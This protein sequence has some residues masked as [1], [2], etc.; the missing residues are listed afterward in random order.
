MLINII[1]SASWTLH[2]RYYLFHRL[3]YLYGIS[4]TI[5]SWCASCL[6]G[7][8]QY[9]TVTGQSSRPAEVFF[10]VP[11]GSVLGPI[12]F[13]LC[14]VPLIALI[15]PQWLTGRKTPS[16]LLTAPLC[17][18]TEIHPVSNQSF[19]DD[20]QLL[21]SCPPDQ[22][23]AIA[24]TMQ[25]CISDVKTWMTQ[26]KLKLND[27]K[28]EALVMKLNRTIF[29]D[30]QPTSL[31]AGTADIPFTTCALNFGFFISDNTL[32]R[33]IWTVCSSAYV[34]IRHVSSIRQYLTVE[35]AKTLLCAFVLSE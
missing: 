24:L 29:P 28:T 5:R 33:H 11:Q 35:A 17:S 19:A 22:I 25:T 27:D 31:R 16:Y 18:L 10:G 4:G 26:Y 23:Y 15:Y 12:L 9:L 21:Q 13:I 6:T 34:E 32:D 2:L 20:T 30:A 7:R 8:T 3:Q 14:S 1:S